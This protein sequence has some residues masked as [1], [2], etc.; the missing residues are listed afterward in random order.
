ML[1]KKQVKQLKGLANGLDAI[2]QIGKYEISDNLIQM[3]D[4]A[5][6]KHELIKIA[7]NRS[8]SEQKEII[9]S[10]ISEVLHAE[11][12]QIIGNVIVLF[13]RN[14]KEPKIKLVA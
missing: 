9:A 10:E 3:L 1:N 2:Y 11:L 13:R 8:V 6:T 4:K 14:L 12:I 7:L 5:L